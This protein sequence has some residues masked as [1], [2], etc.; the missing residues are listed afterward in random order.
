MS[1]LKTVL[2]SVAGLLIL[3]VLGAFVYA[4]TKPDT[5]R[6][7]RSMKIDAPAEKIF[8]LIVD[9][10]SWEK[11]S[12]WEKLDPNM[13]RSYS[14]SPNGVGTIYE[15]SGN[16]D[17]GKGRM[18][19]TTVNSPTKIVIKLDFLEP[20]EAHNTA[21]FTLSPKDGGNEVTWAMYGPNQFVSKI[22]G[23]FYDMDEM[24]GKDFE[25]G[26]NSIKTIVETR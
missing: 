8:A 20:F 2:G 21:E 11:W 17:I 26:L 24:I 14:G 23:L 7:Q 6:Y 13:Q 4:S 10:R 18:E 3:I 9:F 19:I 15:W 1:K 25:T 16:K 12:P 22:F 5:F